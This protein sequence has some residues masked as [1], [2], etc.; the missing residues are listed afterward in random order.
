MTHAIAPAARKYPRTQ[1]SVAVLYS[2]RARARATRSDDAF[3]QARAR[4]AASSGHA[5]FA[6]PIHFE[7][8]PTRRTR[9]VLLNTLLAVYSGTRRLFRR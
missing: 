8:S 3:E 7:P 9:L 6:C 2:A 1:H 5:Y 4:Q